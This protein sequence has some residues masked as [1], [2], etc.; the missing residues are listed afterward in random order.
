MI[1]VG[2]SGFQYPEWKGTFYPRDLPTKAMLPYYAERFPT[3]EIN[4]SFY[5]I[6]SEK[7]LSDWMAAT[8]ARFCFSLKAPKEITHTKKLRDCGDVLQR[9]F[10]VAKTLHEKSGVTL[11][12][13]PPFLKKDAA[14]LKQFLEELPRGCKCAFEF[15]HVSWF[16]D[17]VYGALQS[18][19][20][21]LC[22][23]D[24]E[25]LSTPVVLTAGFGYFR[26]RDEG[27]HDA[28]IANWAKT[29]AR[30]EGQ[31]K[32]IYVYFK[33]EESGIGP[34]FAKQMI[35]LLNASRRD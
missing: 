27:Y 8:P 9:F 33:H 7:T 4:Y 5:R 24:S 13:L 20:V 17:D 15:R 30:H 21:A 3:T 26:L 18:A 6:P 12:Q 34:Q 14:L 10:G 1:W 11:F 22:I 29:I 2:T 25:K 32:D 23:A 31:L 35:D 16:D 28:D 19:G